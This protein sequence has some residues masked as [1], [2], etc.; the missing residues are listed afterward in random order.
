MEL[1]RPGSAGHSTPP[2]KAKADLDFRILA[3]VA[4]RDKSDNP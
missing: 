2:H 1:L 4:K 3:L